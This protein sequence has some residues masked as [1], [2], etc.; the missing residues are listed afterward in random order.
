MGGAILGTSDISEGKQMKKLITILLAGIIATS[1]VACSSTNKTD[2]EICPGKLLGDE[3]TPMTQAEGF[4]TTID[5]AFNTVDTNGNPVTNEIFEGSE[6]GVYLVFWQTDSEKT[7]AELEKLNNLVDTAKKYDYKIVGIVMDG[8][9]NADKA[10][11][12]T[13]DLNFENI[14]WNDEV[15]SR[16]AGID[17]FFSKKY[18]EEN[19]ETFE[20]F[21]ETPNVGDPVS[22]FENSRGQLQ[23]SCS[24]LP[25][26]AEKIEETMKNNNYNATYE[27]LVEQEKE[28]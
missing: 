20:Q 13:K 2:E 22:T 7:V 11:E 12:L 28:K 19:K 21:L 24:L 8:D 5:M 1:L 9:K 15:A 16:Y 26:K 25:V 6:R 4:D 14:V 27:E 23:S 18:Y 3:G 10:K 17:K